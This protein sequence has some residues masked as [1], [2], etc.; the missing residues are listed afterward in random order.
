MVIGIA[1][2]DEDQRWFWSLLATVHDWTPRCWNT[3]DRLPAEPV[4][5][6]IALVPREDGDVAWLA[7]LNAPTLV[8]GTPLHI[9]QRVEAL[10]DVTYIATTHANAIDRLP[11]LIALVV[12]SDQPSTATQLHKEKYVA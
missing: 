4:D 8:L 5:A 10:L 12:A 9:A 2:C 1:A 3:T 11:L 6:W 7:K